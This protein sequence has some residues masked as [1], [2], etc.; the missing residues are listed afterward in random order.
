MIDNVVNALVSGCNPAPTTAARSSILSLPSLR[1]AAANAEAARKAADLQPA[2]WKARLARACCS[3][4]RIEAT[5]AVLLISANADLNLTHPGSFD[6]DRLDDVRNRRFR[7]GLDRALWE[8]RSQGVRNHH[9][10]AGMPLNS[11]A[12]HLARLRDHYAR[13]GTMTLAKRSRPD[14]TEGFPKPRMAPRSAANGLGEPRD[15]IPAPIPTARNKDGPAMPARYISGSNLC[16]TP[17]VRQQQRCQR[18]GGDEAVHRR[19]A[20]KVRLHGD[21]QDSCFSESVL[22]GSVTLSARP[23]VRRPSGSISAR[24]RFVIASRSPCLHGF[25]SVS[26]RAVAGDHARWSP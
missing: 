16:V 9:G 19:V 4:S 25:V 6:F 17:P 26:M 11:D 14:S 12:V 2:V 3:A 7:D 24:V 13:H 8:R 20:P 5:T 18:I 10:Q 15:H 21:G 22:G 1:G 23:A